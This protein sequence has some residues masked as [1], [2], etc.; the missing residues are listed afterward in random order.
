MTKHKEEAEKGEEVQELSPAEKA[1]EAEKAMLDFLDT[2]LT[3]VVVPPGNIKIDAKAGGR[4]T[5][6]TQ[7]EFLII[8]KKYQV[9]NP[10]KFEA[11][12]MR[13][14]ADLAGFNKK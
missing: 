11:K 5:P 2:S 13:F 4:T 12:K 7:E 8:V 6:L 10:I 1:K 14:A 3:S 9:K